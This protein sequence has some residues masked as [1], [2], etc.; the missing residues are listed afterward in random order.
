MCRALLTTLGND[1]FAFL[2][3]RRKPVAQAILAPQGPSAPRGHRAA[4]SHQ[5]TLEQWKKKAAKVELND[6]QKQEIKE[7]FD[8]FD[9]DGSGTID[10][11]ELKIAMRAL[12]FEP[13]KDEVRQMTVEIDKGTGT[14]GFEDFFAIMSV[15][16]S[17]KDEKE[18]I[19]KAFKLFDD[20]ATGSISLNNIKRV[21]KELGENLT[22][23]EL[24]EMLDEAD[25][26]GDGEI[27]EEEFLRM[28]KRT[29]LS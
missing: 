8:L 27:N 25:R 19:L 15:K 26:D 5:T 20:D 7:A 16:M 28:M 23:D 6:V 18:E 12:G 24:Q 17:E 4:S 13:K 2:L 14:I 22:E 29:S 21:A 3:P 1:C 9:V 10:V 11:K